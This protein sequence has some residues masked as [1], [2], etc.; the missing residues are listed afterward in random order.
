MTISRAL[1][2]PTMRGRSWVPHQTG[3][4]PIFGPDCPNF[5]SSE[6]IGEVAEHLQLVAATD[7]IALHPRDD[8]LSAT[9][10]DERQ[11]RSSA[12]SSGPRPDGSEASS[13]AMSPPEQ[14]ALS[15][16]PVRTMTPTRRSASAAP[17]A[18]DQVVEGLLAEGVV[19]LGSVDGDRRDAVLHRV[20]H[21]RQISHPFHRSRSWVACVGRRQPARVVRRA[22]SCA[23]PRW[24]ARAPAPR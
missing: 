21:I 15:P 23:A 9:A 17:K 5:E 3:T 8:R 1:R 16:A 14:N 22:L 20:Q 13:Q 10:H 18:A 12:G 4:L 6:A 11:V 24:A 7:R 19:L 2:S